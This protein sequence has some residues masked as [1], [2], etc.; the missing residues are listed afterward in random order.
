MPSWNIVS[1]LEFT[2]TAKGDINTPL[3]IKNITDNTYFWLDIDA[4][5]WDVIVINSNQKTATKN[6]INILAN[7]IAGSTWLKALWTN[8]FT[9]YDK[10]WWLAE[11]DFDVKI[12]YKDILL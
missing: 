9:I 2:I 12:L 3:Y 6:W 4:V 1:P 7:R 8:Y 11:S 5:A 10:D